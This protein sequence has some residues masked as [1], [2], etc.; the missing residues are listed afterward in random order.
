MSDGFCLCEPGYEAF[1]DQFNRIEGD[2]DTDCQP[3]VFSRCAEGEYRNANSGK[4]DSGANDCVAECGESGGTFLTSVGVCECNDVPTL[5]DVC[6]AQCRASSPTLSIDPITGKLV[7]TD[8]NTTKEID[9]S[10]SSTFLGNLECRDTDPDSDGCAVQTISTGAGGFT[11]TY[12]AT[13]SSEEDVGASRR[14]LQWKSNIHQERRRL[15]ENYEYRNLSHDDF[16]SELESL[17]TAA[18]AKS[19]R[20]L[21]DAP[22]G[23]ENPCICLSN[24]DA[25]LFSL[26]EGQAN[27]PVYV[28]DSLLNTNDNFD[29]GDFRALATKAKSSGTLDTFGFTFNEP[30]VYTFA[31][32]TDANART[33]VVVM[34]TGVSC[35]TEAA[36]V[37]FTAANLVAL[38]VARNSDIVLEPNW[39]LIGGLLGALFALIALVIGAL[40]YFRRK[41]WANKRASVPAY[42]RHARKAN[43]GKSHSKGSVQHSKIDK[44]KKGKG[45]DDDDDMEQHRDMLNQ[46]EDAAPAGEVDLEAQAARGGGEGD[47]DDLD[48][49]DADDLD[50]ARLVKKMQQHYDK[51]ERHFLDQN[52]NAQGHFS[53]LKDEADELKRLL[54]Q[55]MMD[56]G[57][58]GGG[59][60]ETRENAMLFKQLMAEVLARKDFEDWLLQAK[61]D[62]LQLLLNTEKA[63][64]TGSSA[65][66]K[67]ATKEFSASSPNKSATMDGI[68]Q[69]TDKAIKAIENKVL[70][71]STEEKQRQATSLSMWQAAHPERNLPEDMLEMI[72]T[73]REKDEVF[74]KVLAPCI[75]ELKEYHGTVTDIFTGLKPMPSGQKLKVLVQKL[76]DAVVRVLKRLQEADP[77]IDGKAATELAREEAMDARLDCSAKLMQIESEIALDPS[78]GRAT[79]LVGEVKALLATT[80]ADAAKKPK[81]Q[82][83]VTLDVPEQEDQVTMLAEKLKL[84]EVNT[85]MALDEEQEVQKVELQDKLDQK[86][87]SEHEQASLIQQFEDDQKEIQK[88]LQGERERQEEELRNQVERRK[89]QKELKKQARGGGGEKEAKL[90]QQQAQDRAND[91]AA[92]NDAEER[93]RQTLENELQLLKGTHAMG[94]AE[95]K[96]AIGGV[97]QRQQAKLQQRIEARKKKRLAELQAESGG[98]ASEEAQSQLLVALEKEETAD[99]TQLEEQLNAMEAQALKGQKLPQAAIANMSAAHA[100][101][102]SGLIDAHAKAI[103]QL[104]ESVADEKAKRRARM[105][106]RR[107]KRK[108]NK[109]G[110]LDSASPEEKVA[111]LAEIEAEEKEE[112]QQLEVE[113]KALDTTVKSLKKEVMPE[114][115]GENIEN[116]LVKIDAEFDVMENDLDRE[117]HEKREEVFDE[118][119]LSATGSG[120]KA[121]I[122]DAHGSAFEEMMAKNGAA[123]DHLDLELEAARNRKEARLK[124]RLRRKNA[125]KQA[126]LQNELK[127]L[128]EEEEEESTAMIKEL[129]QTN[130]ADPAKLK[131]EED[132]ALAQLRK[133]HDASMASLEQKMQA[134]RN[135]K[136]EKMRKRLEAKRAK[137]LA[138]IAQ[139]PEAEKA[140]ALAVLDSEDEVEKAALAAEIGASEAAAIAEAKRQLAENEAL[141]KAQ[142]VQQAADSAA[143]Q[144]ALMQREAAV[145]KMAGAKALEEKAKLK[146]EEDAAFAQLRNEHDASMDG[147]QE[148][149]QAERSAKQEKLRKRLEA[150]KAKKLASIAQKPE[151][152]KAEALA[153]LHSEEEEEKTALAAELVETEGAAIAEAKRQLAENEALAKAKLVQQA[154]DAADAATQMKTEQQQKLDAL[155][156]QHEQELELLKQQLVSAKDQEMASLQEAQDAKRKEKEAELATTAASE[157]EKQVALATLNEELTREQQ[158]VSAEAEAR[159]QQA[160]AEEVAK[161]AGDAEVVAQDVE[162]ANIAAT[163]KHAVAQA[164]QQLNQDEVS[165]IKQADEAELAGVTAEFAAEKASK[166]Q[167]MKDRLEKRRV[168]KERMRARKK[169]QETQALASMGAEVAAAQKEDW[170]AKVQE[171][172][173]QEAAA[174]PTA[175][176]MRLMEEHESRLAE[177]RQK[178][179]DDA[180][181]L[182]SDANKLEAEHTAML[183]KLEEEHSDSVAKQQAEVEQKRNDT[184]A[185]IAE[186]KMNANIEEA[187][188]LRAE[189]E[190]ELQSQTAVENETRNRKRDKLQKRLEAKKRKK[191]LEMKR[192]QEA[193][194]H[195]LEEEQKQEHAVLQAQADQEREVRAIQHTLQA[196]VV[197]EDDVSD[198]IEMVVQ[199][200]HNRETSDMLTRHY[201]ERATRLR[202]EL[203]SLFES[204]QSKKTDLLEQ[205]KADGIDEDGRVKQL[206]E[207]DHECAEQQRTVE[208]SVIS[209]LEGKHAK[210][211]IQLRQR[212]LGEVADAFKQ[213][214]PEDAVKRQEM[215]QAAQ[216]QEE[217]EQFQVLM[218]NQKA[219]RI[220]RLKKQKSEWEIQM[221]KEGAEAEA[222]MERE[223]QEYREREKKKAEEL[224][225]QKREHHEKEM[226]HSMEQE[227]KELGEQANQKQKDELIERFNADKEKLEQTLAADQNK[228]KSQM[229]DRLRKRRERKAKKSKAKQEED[230]KKKEEEMKRKIDIV[231]EGAKKVI[232][233]QKQVSEA[234]QA[235]GF[236][237]DA[238][239]WGKLKA[240]ASSR[241]LLSK[242][243]SIKALFGSKGGLKI[244]PGGRRSSDPAAGVNM[245]APGASAQMGSGIPA[246]GSAVVPA[247]LQA[248]L[249]SIEISLQQVIAMQRNASK[250]SNRDTE[251]KLKASEEKTA[252]AEARNEALVSQLQSPGGLP[253][254]NVLMPTASGQGFSQPNVVAP[255]QWFKDEAKACEG[256]LEEVSVATLDPRQTARLSFGQAML[257]SMGVGTE[258]GQSIKLAVASKLPSNANNQNAFKDEFSFDPSSRMLYVREDR[259]QHVGEMAA[260]LVHACAHIKVDPDDLSDDNNPKF[261][262][263]LHRCVGTLSQQLFKQ[264]IG[265]SAQ[266][267]QST[268]MAITATPATP[269]QFQPQNLQARLQKY[270]LMLESQESLQKALSSTADSDDDFDN[271]NF[272]LDD[273]GDDDSRKREDMIFALQERV[274]QAERENLR[275]LESYN[276]LRDSSEWVKTSLQEADD[277]SKPGLQRQLEKA[278]AE[279]AKAAVV[280][281]SSVSRLQVLQ[282]E[283]GRITQQ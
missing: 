50:I 236:T 161:L 81:S 205:M 80:P 171:M 142:L 191:E 43:L 192:Q 241:H 178:Q 135:L 42:R 193:E 185:K 63:L 242:Q 249:T 255:R 22:T 179:E 78:D 51:I 222:E 181:A 132:A 18:A 254:S 263:E 221:R 8:G 10:T 260:V 173:Q 108:A 137:K 188:R 159:K 283:L 167:K 57:V 37:P 148:K 56:G 231:E 220:Q 279:L 164:M 240:K 282:D 68:Y 261:V 266:P 180:K 246:A 83:K 196:G 103:K 3:G 9:P 152:E 27:Y 85:Q 117:L 90:K 271:I 113:L 49:W 16:D 74:D 46:D 13:L 14:L 87:L 111:I 273:D 104:D 106:E 69:V 210:E 28:K 128:E 2:G 118:V 189:F 153:V 223:Q 232:D 44:G 96:E 72:S 228:K 230:S 212:Q 25:L 62:I 278:D 162:K 116:A 244:P 251:A 151:A 119:R 206:A 253:P 198:A 226:S 207:L 145:R 98:D 243:G 190:A 170:E 47:Y 143:D 156:A 129:A 64:S 202:E 250:V 100:E 7:E 209:E 114:I 197:G 53:K 59:G 91:E 127:A 48:D 245:L 183:A 88:A 41:G 20:M 15:Q 225:R 92:L 70:A 109:S 218:E 177:L 238:G 73:M 227:L 65:I 281:D 194:R 17:L 77:V 12:G 277:L 55:A 186:A 89:I 21:A 184:E 35:S 39:S 101:D 146:A 203:E 123:S 268:P 233:E 130:E 262:T 269:V 31:M 136:Q 257:E 97:R 199:E 172:I 75:A 248:K 84:Q 224:T 60:G 247:E 40:Y 94:E 239:R 36:I 131:V 95:L 235:G 165:R 79:K 252:K 270:G 11:G 82:K 45:G 234:A 158:A 93:A 160:L 61:Q 86:N 237:G 166:E 259:L 217:L 175:E 215:A 133:D 34:D 154:A 168:Q 219:D 76:I 29:Y 134:E 66:A 155:Q 157:E 208:A 149:M 174:G 99:R 272:L 52:D 26:G 102:M 120:S 280:R 5:D 1:D 124:E 141:A 6:D 24:G 169:E 126:N 147:L 274:D 110:E 187:E 38:N 33:V 105:E 54:T 264:S 267:V 275:A 200:R 115:S 229:E 19:E 182:A 30:G 213:L 71:P 67:A 276:E 140:E 112:E 176:Q 150:K 58:G 195:E 121:V 125:K 258:S 122:D 204:K 214:A 211:Q 163:A 216:M 265:G 144:E 138:S 139:L 256:V 107:R 23:I 201:T 4:C 32:S